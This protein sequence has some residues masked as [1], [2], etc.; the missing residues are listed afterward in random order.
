MVQDPIGGLPPEDRNG[1]SRRPRRRG[2]ILR[3][4]LGLFFLTTLATGGGVVALFVWAEKTYVGPGPLGAETTVVIEPGSGL[5]RIAAD[6]VEAGV[7][8][9]PEVFTAM[10]RYSGDHRRL[11]AGEFRFPPGVSQ[12]TVA[13]MLVNHEVVNRFVTIP[14]GLTSTEIFALIEQADGLTGPM[15]QLP[16]EGS[17]LPETYQ[18]VRGDAR[19]SLI[20]RMTVAMDATVAGL[21]ETR[22]ENLPYATP[23]EAVILAS[24]VEKE[25]GVAGERAR[26]AGVFVNRLRKGMRLQ[27]D[28]TVVFA[29]TGGRVPLGRALTRRDLKIDHPYNTYGIDGLPP[30][31]IANPGRESLAAAMNPAQTEDL[32]FVADGTGGHAFAETLAEHN[33]NVAKWRKRRGHTQ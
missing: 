28:P 7:I 1:A 27:S 14:E 21:W 26:I 4:A 10:L 25:T 23:G 6:L 18:Y 11:T 13:E 19:S 9:Q 2:R 24:I 32:F 30:G 15:P 29:L 16:P 31:P 33:R 5:Q 8:V 20:R 3:A 12:K 22:S 17:L